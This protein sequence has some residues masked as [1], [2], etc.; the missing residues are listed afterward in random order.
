MLASLA[1]PALLFAQARPATHPSPPTTRLQVDQALKG[2]IV[3][4]VRIVGNV[5]VSTSSILN[6]IRTRE[7]DRFDPATVEEDYQR[8]YGMKRFKQVEAKVEPTE[9]GVIVVF[10]VAEQRQVNSV[11][12]IGNYNIETSKIEEA[13]DI[14]RGEA[15]DGFRIA[16]AKQEIERLYHS[17][18]YPLA[19][20]EIDK[21]RLNQNGDLVFNIVEGPNVRVRKIAFKGAHSFTSDKLKDQIKTKY[22]IFIFRPG[23]LDFDSVDDDVAALERFYQ[24]KGFFDVRIGRRLVWSPDQ[25]EVEVDFTVDEGAHY[26]IDRITFKGN[27]TVTEKTLRENLKLTEGHY[28]DQEIIDRDVRQVVKSYSPYGFIYQGQ[29]L[30]Q[31]LENPDY[32]HI[33]TTPVYRREAG[34]VEL[35]YDIHEG[36]PFRLG[37]ILVKGN[38]RSQDKLV[39]R[40]MRVAPGQLYNSAEL[41]DAKDRIKGTPYFSNVQMTPVGDDPESRDLLVEVTE[42][43]TASFNIGAGINSNGGLS[44]NITYEQKNFDI[45]NVPPSWVD[46]FSDRAFTGAGQRFRVSLEP[47]TIAT[48]ASVLF[49]EPYLFDQPYSFT[50]EAYFRDRV[51]EHYDETRIGDRVSFGKRFGYFDALTLSFRGEAVDIHSIADP[52]IRAP[53]IVHFRG[54]SEITS[55]GLQFRHDTTNRGFLPSKGQT[56][57]IG[58]EQAGALGGNFQFNKLSAGYDKYVTLGEDLL[59][60]KTIL[61]L[62]GDAGYIFGGAPFF[63]RFYGGGIGSIRGFRFRG[64]SPRAGIDEDPVGG[65][66][67]LTGTA[68]VSFPLAADILRYVIFT[69]VGD[70]ERNLEIGTIRSSVGTGIRLVLP[71]LGQAPLA[72]DVAFPITKDRQDDTQIFSFSFG[73]IQ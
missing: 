40:E 60:R 53:E 55:V 58:D 73:F 20:V 37:R 65:D 21:D 10:T 23:T 27:A 18:N 25:R 29:Q 42:N 59:D 13:V 43:R 61:A 39:L 38:A 47:G 49:S 3:E 36:K 66:F 17:K 69:D 54:Q 12:Y 9:T 31:K 24:G 1:T 26:K 22:W 6:L 56:F 35:V 41:E 5:T 48:N 62:H 2:K 52:P 19:H 16:L 7:G 4:G 33:R 44:G 57:T 8:I 68:E 51:R 30:D 63:E 46:L 70:V 67:I 14:R 71:F 34:T 45:A 11:A 15:I 28:W 32:L 50:E 72:F 64:V